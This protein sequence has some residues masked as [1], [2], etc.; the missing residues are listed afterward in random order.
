[1]EANVLNSSSFT[2]DGKP[3]KFPHKNIKPKRAFLIGG[4]DDTG[5]SSAEEESTDRPVAMSSP[6]QLEKRDKE[7]VKFKGQGYIIINY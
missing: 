6:E 2:L 3:E 5:S 1:M 7:W 4:S